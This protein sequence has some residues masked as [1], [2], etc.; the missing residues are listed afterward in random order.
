MSKSRIERLWDHA[1]A[2]NLLAIIACNDARDVM[3]VGMR[4]ISPRLDGWI[5][6]GSSES[7]TE[8]YIMVAAAKTDEVHFRAVVLGVQHDYGLSVVLAE[9]FALAISRCV[10]LE[11]KVQAL[12][13]HQFGLS[14]R[15]EEP[16]PGEIVISFDVPELARPNWSEW[17]ECLSAAYCE[18]RGH[19]SF[20]FNESQTCS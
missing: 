16:T 19:K 10:F 4:V 14:S 15:I 1:D 2:G 9:G 11:G 3:R 6:S 13:Q 7:K 17:H 20:S 12:V 8:H 18:L 5:G